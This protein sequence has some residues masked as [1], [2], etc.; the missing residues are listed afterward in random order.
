[1]KIPYVPDSKYRPLNINQ[2]KAWREFCAE[3]ASRY[4]CRIIPE[5]HLLSTNGR[6]REFVYWR[7]Y[8]MAVMNAHGLSQT[9]IANIL[10]LGDHTSVLNGLR[11]AHGHDGKLDGRYEPLWTKEHFEK[12]ALADEQSALGNDWRAA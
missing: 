7:F 2:R 4:F 10:E 12:L 1:M 11:R 6:Y 9:R 3:H 8:A 5:Y